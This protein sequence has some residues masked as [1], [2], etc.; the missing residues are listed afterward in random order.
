MCL[1]IPAFLNTFQEVLEFST[2]TI[3]GAR[4]YWNI[5]ANTTVNTNNSTDRRLPE[6]CGLVWPR[7]ALQID[8]ADVHAQYVTANDAV[9]DIVA[10]YIFM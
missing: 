10:P 7:H 4:L 3:A 9:K 8:D 2:P 6:V 5:N 1:P